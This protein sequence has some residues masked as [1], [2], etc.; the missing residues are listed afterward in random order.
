MSLSNLLSILFY[1]YYYVRINLPSYPSDFSGEFSFWPDCRRPVRIRMP[2]PIT[3]RRLQSSTLRRKFRF[4]TT[5]ASSSQ[6]SSEGDNRSVSNDV[7]RMSMWMN[8][9]NSAEVCSPRDRRLSIL[10]DAY[11]VVLSRSPRFIR[12]VSRC[13]MK[14]SCSWAALKASMS[15]VLTT[16]SV[17]ASATAAV[18]SSVSMRLIPR[19]ADLSA[20]NRP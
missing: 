7:S 19:V 9:S 20:R 18:S 16:G 13:M 8:A 6:F 3:T 15:P 11:L 17:S 14:P 4:P 2:A 5:S 12:M 1:S 10:A